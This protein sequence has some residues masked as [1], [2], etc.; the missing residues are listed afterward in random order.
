MPVL[1]QRWAAILRRYLSSDR[2]Q[3]GLGRISEHNSEITIMKAR[4]FDSNYELL[5]HR[6]ES[7]L[8]LLSP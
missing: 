3:V 5:I 1:A 6:P 8:M 2:G 4:R 7:K